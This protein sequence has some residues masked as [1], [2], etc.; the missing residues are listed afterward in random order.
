MDIEVCTHVCA[1]TCM[2]AFGIFLVTISLLSCVLPSKNDKLHKQV[3]FLSSWLWWCWCFSLFWLSAISCCCQSCCSA[4]SVVWQFDGQLREIV[5]SWTP[6][7]ALI[8]CHSVWWVLLHVIFVKLCCELE[9]AFFK[10]LSSIF[11]FPHRCTNKKEPQ[12]LWVW[13]GWLLMW[14]L[15]IQTANEKKVPKVNKKD[16]LATS[17]VKNGNEQECCDDAERMFQTISNECFKWAT[18]SQKT[19][20]GLHSC[21]PIGDGPWQWIVCQKCNRLHLGACWFASFWHSQSTF[22]VITFIRCHFAVQWWL[23]GKDVTA[24][25]TITMAWLNSLNNVEMSHQL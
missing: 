12:F 9:H 11:Q 10:M 3:F 22:L 4:T 21:N 13:C 14:L 1:W 16:C 25:R 15:V 7:H 6:C 5:Q 23:H 2:C 24:Q 8:T 18:V 19:C 20:H 17:T